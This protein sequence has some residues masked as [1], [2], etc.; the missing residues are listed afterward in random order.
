MNSSIVQWFFKSHKVNFEAAAI[1]HPDHKN[2]KVTIF[3]TL[4]QLD[5]VSVMSLLP[6]SMFHFHSQN[7]LELNSHIKLQSLYCK[8][9][10]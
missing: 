6:F 1:L 8:K 5:L 2:N 3:F 9:W 4:N 7:F 10:C